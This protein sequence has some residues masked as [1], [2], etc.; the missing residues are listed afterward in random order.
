MRDKITVSKLIFFLCLS[1][2]AGIFFAPSGILLGLFLIPAS[3]FLTKNRLYAVFCILFFLIGAFHFNY[4]VYKVPTEIDTP[5]YGVVKEPP[6]LSGKFQKIVIDYGNGRSLLFVDRYEKYGYGDYLKVEGDFNIP[7]DEGYRNYLRK[8]GIYHTAFYPEIEKKEHKSSFFLSSIYNLKEK[9]QENIRGAVPAP[10]VFLLEAMVLG[11]RSSFSE[12]LNE[13]LSVSGTRH[14]TAISG[15]HI[16][17]VS[18]M[19]FYLIL[20]FK[21][22]KRWAALASILII[23]LF[24]IFVGAS[25]SA[26]RAGIMGSVFMI[27]YVFYRETDLSRLV[28]FAGATMLAFNPLLLHYDLGFQLSFL[29][30]T[31]IL[32]LHNPVKTFLTGRSD[33][34]DFCYGSTGKLPGK[35]R[36]FFRNNERIADILAVTVGAQLLVFPLILYN[37][38][39]IS[40]Y[41]VF[42]NTL[43][44]PLLPFIMVFGF[45]TA[46]TGF[47]IFAFPAFL[48]LS[49]VL[50]VIN[51]IYSFPFSAIYLENVPAYI[52]VFIYI[53]IFYKIYGLKK[54]QEREAHP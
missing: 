39:H 50:F 30:V 47:V 21:V 32:L 24:V 45:L 9:A 1:F 54:K 23:A 51:M 15:M 40:L 34:G 19:I 28:V 53:F 4:T 31:G 36:L 35:G 17:I 13:R 12:E 20:F 3:Y 11:D 43:I 8:E 22:K 41:S 10:Q 5:V 29:A 27:S 44:V 14:I 26:I 7:E 48:L 49:I 42:A 2:I 46:V 18:S 37:F 38:G 33:G 25:T 6:S 52:I 16:V